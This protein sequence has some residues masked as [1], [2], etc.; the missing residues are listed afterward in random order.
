[1]GEVRLGPIKLDVVKFSFL[2]KVKS[3]QNFVFYFSEHC[4]IKALFSGT[5]ELLGGG[6]FPEHT[7]GRDHSHSLCSTIQGRRQRVDTPL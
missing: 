6:G 4:L 5:H 3:N 7:Q 2:G 1:L